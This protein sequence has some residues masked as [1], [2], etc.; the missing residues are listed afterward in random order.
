MRKIGFI[1]KY[2]ENTYHMRDYCSDMIDVMTDLKNKS[3][4][5][6]EKEKCALLI[7]KIQVFLEIYEVLVKEYIRQNSPSTSNQSEME[8][9]IRQINCP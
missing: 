9:P 4:T 1:Q 8:N 3:N 2:V 7:K 6:R 5:S